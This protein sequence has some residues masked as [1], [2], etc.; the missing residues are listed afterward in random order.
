[1]DIDDEIQNLTD[2][3]I[4]AYKRIYNKKS[5]KLYTVK[6]WEDFD[7]L[8]DDYL[9]LLER[10]DS[11]TP[12]LADFKSSALDPINTEESV[13]GMFDSDEKDWTPDR[14]IL[15]YHYTLCT[16][17]SF[18]IGDIVEDVLPIEMKIQRLEE[19]GKTKK[20]ENY[21]Q[22]LEA[23]FEETRND[24]IRYVPF[25]GDFFSMYGSDVQL[26][27]EDLKKHDKA[28]KRCVT[29]KECIIE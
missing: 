13:F 5:N 26:V 6:Y 21:R 4:R 28:F 11:M 10:I 22:N 8:E 2:R 19:E 18:F 16:E 24:P 27:W 1:M 15:A 12:S 7:Y 25:W 20:A 29:G 17:L 3:K 23:F 14:K 9:V